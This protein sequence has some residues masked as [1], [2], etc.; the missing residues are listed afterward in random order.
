VKIDLLIASHARELG[1]T[2]VTHDRNDFEN[3]TVQQLLD[4]DLVTP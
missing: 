4:V 1:A 2:F 3:A